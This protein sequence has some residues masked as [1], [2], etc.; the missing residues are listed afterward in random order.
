MYLHL[1][2]NIMS[3]MSKLM[4]KIFFS[5]ICPMWF[6]MFKSCP[7]V[8]KMPLFSYSCLIQ[9]WGPFC[10]RE[11]R[12]G[13]PEVRHWASHRVGQLAREGPDGTRVEPFGGGRWTSD[14]DHFSIELGSQGL[15]QHFFLNWNPDSRLMWLSF[16]S[17]WIPDINNHQRRILSQTLSPVH[18]IDTEDAP[19]TDPATARRSRCFK[20]G[21]VLDRSWSPVE[22][23]AWGISMD[24]PLVWRVDIW[25]MCTK[26]ADMIFKIHIIIVL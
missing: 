23:G 8:Q 21:M 22:C 3:K 15:E 7:D 4:S 12:C 25:V 18:R 11:L 14:T 19:A 13:G 5:E 20:R 2:I 6:S 10:S 9:P 16:Y 26:G 17:S 24:M 1:E